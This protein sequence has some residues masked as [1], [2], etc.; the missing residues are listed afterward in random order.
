MGHD[1]R[2]YRCRLGDSW[3][4]GEGVEWGKE[5]DLVEFP[6]AWHLDDFPWFEY[7]PPQGGNLTPPSAVLETWLG[8][9]DWA[10]IH[11]PGGVLTYTMHPQVIG[12]GNRM[13]MLEQLIEEIDKREVGFTTLEKAATDWRAAHPFKQS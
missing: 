6:W 1:V 4:K 3:V 5:V 13:L 10:L 8:D 11:E 2:P 9:L 12:R 7:I